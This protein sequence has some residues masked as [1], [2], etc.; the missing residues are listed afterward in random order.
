MN[1]YIYLL[2]LLSSLLRNER[3][4]FWLQNVVT[5]CRTRLSAAV[6]GVVAHRP[7]ICEEKK[8]P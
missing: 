6:V 1:W 3:G 5:G 7:R 8:I 4:E 2:F